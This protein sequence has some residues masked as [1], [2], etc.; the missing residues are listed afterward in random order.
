MRLLLVAPA[1]PRES[2][3]GQ[4]V[5]R[6]PYLSLTT[7]AALTG[8][9]WEVRLT[10]E[11][12]ES[13]DFADHP[14]LVGISVMTPLARRA[15]EIADRFRSEGVPVVLGGIHPTMMEEEARAHADV[16]VTG[17]AEA[18]WA[19][20]LEDFRAGRLKP[21]YRARDFV[22]ME[23]F[24]VP[25]RELLKKKA[26][27]FTNTIQT[28]R[29]CPFDCDFC[30]VTSFYGRT[31]RVRPVEDVVEEIEQMGGG[32]LFFVDDNI[33]GKPRYAKDLF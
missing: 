3:W 31:Y 26:Y 20:L 25:R 18:V 19:T 1:W 21:L 28:S 17:E 11:N 23:R 6:F 30:S 16:V 8:D 14:D 22:S 2:L 10:D 13:I 29:G 7:L 33:A 4:I 5:F 24:P 15:Y 32:F 9:E 27:F 12:V